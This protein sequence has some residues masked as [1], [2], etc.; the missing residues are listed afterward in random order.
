MEILNVEI[1]AKCRNPDEIRSM[2]IEAGADFKGTDHQIDTYFKVNRGRLK[3]REGNI[4][5]SLIFYDR[6]NTADPKASRV[7]LFENRTDSSLKQLL[8]ASLGV[9]IVVDKVREIYFI[10][11]VKFHLDEVKNLGHF[12]E[13]EAIDND[14]TIGRDQLQ[15]QCEGY[16]KKFHIKSSDLLPDSYSDMLIG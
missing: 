6:D 13:I 4:E 10:E 14:G 8:I 15:K 1:R 16:M 2:L 7:I 3:L 5:Q 9:K 11:N 12:I